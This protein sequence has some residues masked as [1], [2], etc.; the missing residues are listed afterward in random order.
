[1]MGNISI[2]VNNRKEKIRVFNVFRLYFIV[3]MC[4]IL[5]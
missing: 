5:V 1:M 4:V 3:F 2:M